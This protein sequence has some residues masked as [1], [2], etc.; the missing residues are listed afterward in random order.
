MIL[1][2][3]C[4]LFQQCN[5]LSLSEVK[6]QDAKAIEML[7]FDVGGDREERAFC[8]W[9]TSLGVGV[10]SIVEDLRDGLK[11]LEVISS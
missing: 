2:F 9:M 11:L 1:L 4:S 7:S 10:K 5:G 6:Q 8:N 3:L